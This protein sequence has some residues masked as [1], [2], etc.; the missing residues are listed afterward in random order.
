MSRYLIMS[1]IHGRLDTL[2][3]ILD[4][5]SEGKLDGI[6]IAGD[7]EVDPAKISEMIYMSFKNPPCPKIYMVRG[8]CDSGRYGLQD[9]LATDAGEGHRIFLT[10]GH[11]YS[12][13]A[14]NVMLAA[15]ASNNGA[16]I[17]VYG[18]T[19]EPCDENVAGVRCINPGAVCG[20]YFSH[21]SYAILAIDAGIV[22]EHF[23]L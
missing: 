13:K 1:D 14:D 20:G 5:E 23:V 16:D 8:N 19:H 10:H 9:V 6:L 21:S 4:K 2:Q 12:V 3:K 7:I 22:V 15:V 11:R 18:H 17:A